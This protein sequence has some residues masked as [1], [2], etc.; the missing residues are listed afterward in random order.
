VDHNKTT[1]VGR[2]TANPE[3]YPAGIR[4]QDHCQFTIAVNRVV[5]DQNGPR[6]DFIPCSLWGPACKAFVEQRAK[7]DE[8]GVIGRLRANYVPQPDGTSHLLFEVRVEEI[9][10]GRKSLKNM[11]PAPEK[12]PATAAVGKLQEEFQA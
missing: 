2:L 3:Y 10:L 1:L 5:S 11:Q 4:G 7:G 8:V 6:A 9:H 12:T